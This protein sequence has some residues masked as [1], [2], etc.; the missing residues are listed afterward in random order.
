MTAEC[1]YR[2]NKLIVSNAANLQ[3]FQSPPSPI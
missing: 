1:L 3:V 2:K